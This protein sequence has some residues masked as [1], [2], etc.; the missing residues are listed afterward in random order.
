MADKTISNAAVREVAIKTTHFD[1]VD[2]ST[3]YINHP[4]RVGS[5][6]TVDGLYEY[7]P[8]VAV[9][10]SITRLGSATSVFQNNPDGSNTG[11][12]GWG[13]G[14]TSH[15]EN[16]ATIGRIMIDLGEVIDLVGFEWQ[17]EGDTGYGPISG[18]NAI[19]VR[20]GTAP[21]SPS[22]QSTTNVTNST[23][24][25]MANLS[26][27]ANQG[28]PNGLAEYVDLAALNG[29]Q[30]WSAQYIAFDCH[31][32]HDTRNMTIRHILLHART[33]A[34]GSSTINVSVGDAVQTFTI[35]DGN[36][37]TD[38]GSNTLIDFGTD[39]LNLTDKS[40]GT[41]FD[42]VRTGGTFRVHGSDGSDTE[43]TV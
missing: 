35:R 9:D 36:G 22:Y 28:S 12:T 31:T 15:N 6:G 24:L 17:G 39:Q 33:L 34:F 14:W 1:V 40:R 3:Y 2:G 41:K 8:L 5:D 7:S 19:T 10:A 11:A 38:I 18:P 13:T 37:N 29:G 4:N 42:V 26:W 23:N 30:P 27:G 20:G 43:V 32:S 25:N 21:L 16:S